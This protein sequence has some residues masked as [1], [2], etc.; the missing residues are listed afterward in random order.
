MA[1]IL[2]FHCNTTSTAAS[3]VSDTEAGSLFS[4]DMGTTSKAASY[5]R[6][7][8][9]ECTQTRADAVVV[10]DFDRE[11]ISLSASVSEPESFTDGDVMEKMWYFMEG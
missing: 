1:A 3:I 5:S 8:I 2:V 9:V 10:G 7:A 4:V 6:W 11:D